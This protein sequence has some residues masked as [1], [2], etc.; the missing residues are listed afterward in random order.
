MKFFI[1]TLMMLMNVSLT[2]A[3]EKN[4][5]IAVASNFLAPLTE[6]KALFEESSNIRLLLSSASS[7][8]LYAQIEH[9]APYDVFFSADQRLVE[10]LII[11]GK[12]D[13]GSNYVYATGSLVLWS[14][15][16][17]VPVKT[18]LYS[19]DIK[20]LAIANPDVAPYGLAARQVL[21]QLELWDSFKKKIIYGENVG[22]AFQFVASKNAQLGFVALSQILNKNSKINRDNYW[23]VPKQLYS[24]LTQELLVLSKSR[25][26][27]LVR[28]FMAYIKGE[29]AMAIIKSY[30]YQ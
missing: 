22:Q 14:A 21:Q 11:N 12:A 23:V 18:K 30:G 7:S 19:S 5:K 8:K 24:P 16:S 17:S 6:L 2:T 20:R 28:E 13:A 1:L 29:Q 15:D 26:K 4:L 9:G 3:S 25:K 10:K 27:N